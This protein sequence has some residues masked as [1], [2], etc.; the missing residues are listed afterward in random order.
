MVPPGAEYRE[1]EKELSLK[2]VNLE[3]KTLG[4]IGITGTV[5]NE[6]GEIL[7]DAT[8]VVKDNVTGS[9]IDTYYSNVDSGYYYFT[10][11]RGQNYNISY[12][13]KGYL[14]Q[15]ENVNIPK[16]SE[17][18]ALTKNMVLARVKA[19]Y[20]IVLNNIFFDSLKLTERKV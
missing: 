11:N 2:F 1:I 17:Y 15:S 3:S 14:F 10:L 5:K 18:T 20:K 4:T 13:A 7:K 9:L 6:Q 16:Q 8:I 12:E 19:G